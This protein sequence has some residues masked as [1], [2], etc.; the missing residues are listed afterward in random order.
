MVEM[1]PHLLEPVSKPSFWYTIS[2]VDLF[3]KF[4][5]KTVDNLD[6]GDVVEQVLH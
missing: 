2:P 5:D 1:R 4:S 6:G 3:K